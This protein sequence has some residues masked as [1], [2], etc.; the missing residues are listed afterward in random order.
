MKIDIYE[1]KEGILK[2]VDTLY[3]EDLLKGALMGC[4]AEGTYRVV[5][6]LGG[7]R[8]NP[9]YSEIS[10]QITINGPEVSA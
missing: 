5:V 7:Q 3:G 4:Y 1:D 9:V 2:L 10:E 6:R 8:N